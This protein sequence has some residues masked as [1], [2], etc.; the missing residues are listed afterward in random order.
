MPH[1]TSREVGWCLVGIEWLL[2]ASDVHAEKWRMLPIDRRELLIEARSWRVS[3]VEEHQTWVLCDHHRADRAILN[4]CD[5]SH[6]HLLSFVLSLQDKKDAC[7]CP[8]VRKDQYSSNFFISR[9]WLQTTLWSSMEKDPWLP[10]LYLIHPNA[11]CFLKG[12][13]A[14]QCTNLLLQTSS[15]AGD[16][17]IWLCGLV[18]V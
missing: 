18:S 12:Y 9:S 1:W 14:F 5:G 4:D 15:Q 2:T 13:H 7:E 10:V 8:D 17:D 6:F 16:V 11:K 3:V